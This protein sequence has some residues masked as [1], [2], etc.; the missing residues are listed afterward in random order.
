MRRLSFLLIT[1]ALA[2]CATEPA[3]DCPV[4]KGKDAVYIVEHGWHTEIGIPATELRGGMRFFRSVFPGARA[5]MFGYGKKTFFTAPDPS[6]NEYILGPFPGPAVIHAVGLYVLPPEAYPD[7]AVITLALPQ[8]GGRKLSDFIWQDLTKDETGK[9]AVVSR[10]QNPDGMFYDAASEYNLF[11]TC[12]TWTV[13]ALQ[14]AGLPLS[15]D[16]V[17]F[18]GEAMDQF[19]GAKRGQCSAFSN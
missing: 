4:P 1:L 6:L 14:A 11:H 10:S 5:I 13:E 16:G 18:S 12:N 8:D 9:P 19:D 7:K 17:T 3:P 15:G 2:A